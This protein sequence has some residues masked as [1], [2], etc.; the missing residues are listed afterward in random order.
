MGYRKSRNDPLYGK[1]R[2]ALADSCRRL[3]DQV[4]K[5][6]RKGIRKGLENSK[7]E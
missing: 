4:Q 7:G 5:K 3:R 6:V 2:K 1:M